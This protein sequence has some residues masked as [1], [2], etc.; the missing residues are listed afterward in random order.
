[1][2]AEIQTT[3]SVLFEKQTSAVVD[4]AEEIHTAEHL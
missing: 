1:M 2:K 3:A 4:W